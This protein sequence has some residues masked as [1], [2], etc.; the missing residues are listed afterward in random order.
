MKRVQPA[1]AVAL[2]LGLAGYA[3]AQTITASITGTVADPTS[4]AVP[5]VK[6]TAT[7]ADTNVNYSATTNDS[8]VYNLLFL[9]VGRYNVAAEAQGFKK[10][11]LGPFALEVN[12]I[13]RVD[14]K[15]EI[16]DT[17]QSI[18]IHDF[19]PILQ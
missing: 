9:P 12:Q 5:N 15:L 6:I 16:G 14:V 4:A 19:A 7:N 13:A 8:G 11:I 18:E 1:V 17:S 10:V 2:A 3:A